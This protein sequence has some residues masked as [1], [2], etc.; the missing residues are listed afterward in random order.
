L[1]GGHEPS[2]LDD[3]CLG[4]VISKYFSK[5]RFGPNKIQPELECLE[6]I[7][8][9]LYESLLRQ[10]FE[11]TSCLEPVSPLNRAKS[12]KIGHFQTFEV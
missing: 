9:S 12:G 10:G 2:I 3:L 8:L 7:P 6:N 4:H 5:L 1:K 11:N